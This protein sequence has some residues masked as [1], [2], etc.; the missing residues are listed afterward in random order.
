MDKHGI[1]KWLILVA[2]MTFSIMVV[3][4]VRQKVRLG[5]DLKGGTS[6][7]VKI[8]E[9]QIREDVQRE[10]PELDASG[11]D[12]AV[13][14]VLD[15]AQ[16]RALEVLRNRIDNLGIA[17]PVIYPGKDNRIIIQLPGIDESKRAD[18]E[19]S[20]RSVAFLEFRMVH[21]RNRELVEDLFSANAAPEGYRLAVVGG[22]T[23]YLRERSFPDDQRDAAYHRRLGR[24]QVPNAGY[25]FMLM[26][27]EM[28]GQTVYLPH[29][30]R[31]R[32]ELS[33]E[34]LK[35]AR[36]DFQ[37]MMQP[38]VNI[39]FDAQGARRFGTITR[40]YAP[41]GPRNPNINSYRQLAIILDNTLYSAPTIQEPIYGGRA[42]ISGSF[43]LQEAKFLSN[44]LRAGSLPAPVE[45]VETRSVEPSL[46]R[47]SI[48]SGLYAIGYG[49]AGV[50]V[51]MMVYYLVCGVV[52]NAALL[53]NMLLLPLGMI[54][55]AG[56]LSLGLKES[57]GGGPIQLPVLTLPG[58]AGI[59]LTV[60]MAVDANVLIFERIREELKSGKRLLN[61]ISAGY[62]RAFVTIMDANITT[63][64]TGFVLFRF[65]TGPIR[66]FAVTL[67]AGIL[68]SMYTALVVTRMVFSLIAKSSS[69]KTLKMLSI[70]GETKIDF[71]R[72]RRL[73]AVVSITLI[74][75][76]WG[77]LL[78]R[79]SQNPSA[80]LGVDFT[81]GTSATFRFVEK[82]GSDDLRSELQNTAGLSD[83]HVQYQK[84]LKSG[85]AEFLNIKTGAAGVEEADVP[86]LVL[87]ALRQAFPAAG[88]QLIQT[89]TVGAQIGEELKMSA[90][91]SIG[92]ALL[93]IIIY[94]SIR[95]E[96]GFAVGA[97]V[98]LAH[99][100]LIT[101]GIYTLCGRQLSLPVVAALLTI[102]G[103][104]VNDTIV[105]FDRIREDL[106]LT[107][108]LSFKDVCNLSINQTL[109]R[110]LLTSVTTLITV[111][112]LLVFGGGAINDF[113]LALFIGVL[114]GTYSSIF[115][116]TPVVLLW[117]R[118]RKPELHGGKKNS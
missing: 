41:G 81:G 117:H 69:I 74:A 68:V 84:E 98:A 71:V 118:D 89:D 107:R 45:I 9:T 94:I 79:G 20:I 12:G 28:D 17:E 109:S 32:R 51:F 106:R 44:V 52:A 103:Y 116:A 19:E 76:S 86:R 65:G 85:G 18:A 111:S 82:I 33:G 102:V 105:V 15:G 10:N 58:I 37:S 36:V 110:T 73:A 43:T 5:L 97:I 13:Q 6:F 70:I 63:L 21:E 92:L 3:L 1:W 2:L 88:H 8:D 38:V 104:S 50:L 55:A 42:Q 95:F 56:F 90:V 16:E 14:R 72:M 46:G 7:T 54:V 47:D 25:E 78:H 93:M 83:V 115:I 35:D 30:V 48:R 77:M 22:R 75:L 60:G 34:Y 99:D 61:A 114:V 57:V 87:D 66:G 112:M 39:E 113:A 27:D 29:F 4:P 40:D 96:L 11:L 101:V 80:I 100:V 26:R 23:V 67:C 91:L 31:R 53:L 62:D 24:F 59:L 108:N 49:G 64:L